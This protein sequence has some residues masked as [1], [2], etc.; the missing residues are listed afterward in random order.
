MR[1]AIIVLNLFAAIWGAAAIL[2]AGYPRW[3]IAAPILLSVVLTIWSRRAL[4]HL[5]PRTDGA[6][7]GRL[8]GICSAVEGIV[9]FATANLLTNMGM[10]DAIGPAIAIIVGLHFLPLAYGLPARIY[11]L[12][13]GAMVVAGAAALLLPGPERLPAAGIAAA[14]ILWASAV[15]VI[16]RNRPAAG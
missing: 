13:G 2:T 12:T 11:Y 14:G 8:V 6:R 7:I 16:L 10:A 5:G 9:I 3:L 15:A 1:V 4:A